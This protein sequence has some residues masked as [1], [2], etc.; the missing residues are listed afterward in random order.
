MPVS[1]V[2]S[3]IFH[4][5]SDSLTQFFQV[6]RTSRTARRQSRLAVRSVSSAITSEPLLHL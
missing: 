6:I 2:G 1:Y 4:L 3:N 5:S